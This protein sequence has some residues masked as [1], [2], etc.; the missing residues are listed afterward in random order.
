MIVTNN[1]DLA[2]KMR[3]IRVHGSNPKYYHHILGY[4]SRLDEIQAAILNV[5][6]KHLDKW[7]VQRRSIAQKYTDLLNETVKGKVKVPTE[8]AEN[9]HVYHQY[10]IRTENRDKLQQFL[11]ENGIQT[12]IYYPLPLH[13][14]PVFK[15]LG[16]KEGDFPVAEKAAKEAISL[17]MYPELKLEHQEYVVEKIKE[18][19]NK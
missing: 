7:I 4:N 18:F 16:Y 13:I 11:K 12:M 9:F 3:V 14:Q 19:F 2:E 1:D 10:T 5:K 8:R 17:P 15:D 6:F